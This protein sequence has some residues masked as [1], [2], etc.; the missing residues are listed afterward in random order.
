MVSM[1]TNL[2][3]GA[4]GP[5]GAVDSLG[6]MNHS[7]GIA[8]MGAH[9]EKIQYQSYQDSPPAAQQDG[10]G[11]NGS[12]VTESDDERPVYRPGRPYKGFSTSISSSFI[13]PS[14]VRSDCCSMACF[15][16]LQADRTRYLL[17]GTPPPSPLRRVLIHV[18]IPLGL[19]LVAG[20]CAVHIRDAV[21]NQFLCTFLILVMF[22]YILTGCMRG[23]VKRIQVREEM[24]WRMRE[25]DTIREQ[26]G[27]TEEEA[28][29][30]LEHMGGVQSL[31]G[32]PESHLAGDGEFF[33][34][35]DLG[36][37][38]SEMGCAH[39]MCGCYSS[40][41]TTRSVDSELKPRDL[42]GCLWRAFAEFC[43]HRM[44]NCFLQFCGCCGLAQ[45]AREIERLVPASK[46]RFDYVTFEDYV[47]YYGPIVKLRE[48]KNKGLWDHYGALS[49]LSLFLVKSMGV[50]LLVLFTVSLIGSNPNFRLN[51]MAVLLAT[52]AQAFLI[53]YL[54]HWKWNRF[55]LSLDA[56]VKYFA[57][58]FVLTTGLA[59]FFEM[60]E[61]IILQMLLYV[62]VVLSNL[63][64]TKENAYEG[65]DDDGTSSA[66][67]SEASE[68]GS[69]VQSPLPAFSPVGGHGRY[70]G[71]D[72]PFSYVSANATGED[73]MRRFAHSN[74]GIV[75]I[76]LFLN[77][78]AMAALVEE[79]CKYFGYK[80]VEHPDFLTEE[81][82][83]EAAAA[84][85][86]MA[87]S[88]DESDEGEGEDVEASEDA[89]G[90]GARV[91]GIG[92]D[93]RYAPPVVVPGQIVNCTVPTGA[94]VVT[95]QDVP[96]NIG[97]STEGGRGPK[98]SVSVLTTIL[99]PFSRR[100]GAA[101]GD[102]RQEIP[103]ESYKATGV[104]PSSVQ[105]STAAATLGP[106]GG[107]LP[108]K[109]SLNSLG[110]GVTVAMVSVALGFACCENLIYIF[111]YNGSSIGM[112]I[113]VLIA[114]SLFPVH[115]IAAAI[116]SI[117][118]CRRDLE[119]DQS[120]Q[121]GRV[122]S[123]AVLMHGSFDFV[124][125]LVSFLVAL[126]SGNGGGG[127]N[128]DFAAKAEIASFALS[129]TIVLAG[130]A[131]YVKES[132]QQKKRLDEMENREGS[133]DSR[134]FV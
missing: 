12:T 114:R 51:N 90:D 41:L 115:P 88:R 20:W 121:L 2:L 48:E 92:G 73:Y 134:M 81:D 71:V 54:V 19:F 27:Y 49:H 14:T 45:E 44:C 57:C 70:L 74:P 132:R 83:S 84:H 30:A 18:L 50:A 93:A 110:A 82:L 77:A 35:L 98:T 108:A 34:G 53:L 6:D 16:V 63:G 97:V 38:R 46:K 75:I 96:A 43:C 102:E 33:H 72:D 28:R 22:G 89:S 80:M 31:E 60:V 3:G 99:T 117:G 79:L 112:E 133:L 37:T 13:S 101:A 68:Y 65:V 23:T 11:T 52:L 104:D 129:L 127:A 86:A 126:H 131:Y 26:S 94:V 64:V 113:S 59:V 87:S 1:G 125:M 85:I 55:D 25:L 109:R 58:G 39:R 5:S 56:V 76:Y 111:V 69:F 15:G 4:D 100:G 47:E 122:I 62:I 10:A 130:A 29:E 42:C 95:G 32:V 128:D 9:A 119:R 116:Q 78:F 61:T 8:S 66:G 123:P 24:L 91:G 118:V 124:L 7:E 21:I 103:R 106:S 107:L 105:S 120:C 36:Q 67:Y 17:T 40:D